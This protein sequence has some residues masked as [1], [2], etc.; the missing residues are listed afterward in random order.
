LVVLRSIS[1]ALVAPLGRDGDSDH[2]GAVRRKAATVRA[3]EPEPAADDTDD[4]VQLAYS[5][6]EPVRRQMRGGEDGARL[7]H[8]TVADLGGKLVNEA[9]ADLAVPRVEPDAAPPAVNEPVPFDR[10]DAPRADDFVRLLAR[11]RVEVD[12]AHGAARGIYGLHRRVPLDAAKLLG[13]RLPGA[14][15]RDGCNRQALF[16][17]GG[18]FFGRPRHWQPVHN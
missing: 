18:N 4:R 1:Q 6:V 13:L 14:M 3:G 5:I 9:R 2:D 15:R 11:S 7:F 17:R 12:A 16:K 8:I 10:E